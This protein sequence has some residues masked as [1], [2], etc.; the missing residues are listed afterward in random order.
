[1]D[2]QSQVVQMYEGWNHVSKY[3]SLLFVVHRAVH[4]PYSFSSCWKA[5]S[6]LIG[7]VCRRVSTIV[8][9]RILH[10]RRGDLWETRQER[11]C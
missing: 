5:C 8:I 10:S 2:M 11:W 4:G 9:C 7:I 3:A 6:S 1:M